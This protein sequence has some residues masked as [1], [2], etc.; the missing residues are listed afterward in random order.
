MISLDMR[1]AHPVVLREDVRRKL[2]QQSRRRTVQ[3]R[4]VLRSRIV[5]L[6]ADGLQNKQIAATLRAA[7]RMVALWR[8]RFSGGVG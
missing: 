3:A 5:L 7:P 4:V 6:A 2:E 8:G 1:V